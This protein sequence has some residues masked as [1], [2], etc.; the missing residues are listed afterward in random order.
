MA[1]R[2]TSGDHSILSNSTYAY[3]ANRV[4][5]PQELAEARFGRELLK[6][7][8][9]EIV[10]IWSCWMVSGDCV[11]AGRLDGEEMTYTTAPAALAELIS[12]RRISTV[13]GT[14]WWIRVNGCPDYLL[15]D[16]DHFPSAHLL[17]DHVEKLAYL[18][19]E[20]LQL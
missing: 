2:Y 7:H 13:F 3:L 11:L 14:T 10:E 9:P 12:N 16:I 4:A 15:W 8:D 19:I 20:S 18:L 1:V 17:G 6:T 5:G